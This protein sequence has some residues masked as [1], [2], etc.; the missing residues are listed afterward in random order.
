MFPSPGWDQRLLVA[1]IQTIQEPPLVISEHRLM[2]VVLWVNQCEQ[3]GILVLISGSS[4]T[5]GQVREA[6]KVQYLLLFH[7]CSLSLL[8]NLFQIRKANI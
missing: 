5:R 1:Q 3:R 2:L 4:D 8:W 7:L 6:V